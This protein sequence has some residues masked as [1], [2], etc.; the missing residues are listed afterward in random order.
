MFKKKHAPASAC[1]NLCRAAQ[2]R[3]AALFKA[4]QLG[5]RI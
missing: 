2:L 5:P 1:D 4:A 3:E